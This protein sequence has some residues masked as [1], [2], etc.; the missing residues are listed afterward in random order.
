MR[1]INLFGF[2]DEKVSAAEVK[3][4]VGESF[5][6]LEFKELALQICVSYIANTLSKC[7]FKTY[8]NG[9]ETKGKLWYRLNISPNPNE[10]SSQFIHKFVE[11]IYYDDGALLV[12]HNEYLFCA[13]GYSVDESNP[14]VGYTYD[15]ITVGT[16][17]LQ[18][19]YNASGV[20]HMK[21]E[22]TNVKGL[23]DAIYVQYGKLF[24]LAV[25]TYARTNG[26]KYKL[27]LDNYEAGDK[28][29]KGLFEEQLKAQLKT[30]I[31]ADNSVYPQ[32]R[33]TDLQ[34]FSTSTPTTNADVVAWRKETFEVAAQ[35]CK[36]PLPLLY[37]NMTN[38][39]EIVQQFLTF[40]IDPLACMIEEELSRKYF[41]F[42]E[43]KKGNYVVV[44][45]TRINHVD[46][47]D[48]AAAIDKIIGSGVSC[49]DEARKVIGWEELNTEFSK[50]HFLTKN[51]ELAENALK[52][53][54][55]V[56]NTSKGGKSE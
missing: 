55:E 36:I 29:F 49:I 38:V 43:W 27:V 37:G 32:F 9:E 52:R 21:L 50:A 54:G 11:K 30:F 17:T 14:L 46:I 48:M 40:C 34:E 23:V 41:S 3:A 44:D 47:L 20:F 13:D 25:K 26:K 22:N 28:R 7:E 16:H 6:Q 45:T 10:N 2:L 33:G 15:N 56:V 51:Y 18:R 42:A 4:I 39:K 5:N 53:E 24:D 8:E 35:A 1:K 12:P 31:D 19:K